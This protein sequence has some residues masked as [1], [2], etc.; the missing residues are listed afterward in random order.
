MPRQDGALLGSKESFVLLKGSIDTVPRVSSLAVA[1]GDAIEAIKNA[2]VMRRMNLGI[3]SQAAGHN[4]IS[5][6][7]KDVMENLVGPDPTGRCGFVEPF[8]MVGHDMALAG[9][10][11]HVMPGLI[12]P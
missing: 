5:L 8:I 12:A 6:W 3:I 4:P 2:A 1:V 10:E 7:G 9:H 11:V